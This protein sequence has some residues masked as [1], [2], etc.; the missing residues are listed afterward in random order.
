MVCDAAEEVEQLDGR[1][2]GLAGVVVGHVHIVTDGGADAPRRELI[3]KVV[4]PPGL[5]VCR[6][7]LR[8][9]PRLE[10]ELCRVSVRRDP[11]IEVIVSRPLDNEKWPGLLYG[12]AHDVTDDRGLRGLVSYRREYAPGLWTDVVSWASAEQI[13]RR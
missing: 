1:R 8:P 9:M 13:R 2:W 4:L 6:T 10:D 12:W 3:G 5:S 7:T 11:P